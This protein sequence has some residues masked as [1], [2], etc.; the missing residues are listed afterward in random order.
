[1]GRETAAV[2][3]YGWLNAAQ[4]TSAV[5]FRLSPRDDCNWRGAMGARRASRAFLRSPMRRGLVR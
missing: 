4:P 3:I 2:R 5:S 1:M